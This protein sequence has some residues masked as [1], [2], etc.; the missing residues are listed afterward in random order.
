MRS[1]LALTGVV[2]V[3]LSA[4]PA[5]AGG[6]AIPMLPRPAM[7][8]FGEGSVLL[9]PGANILVAPGDR[10]ARRAAERL[11]DMLRRSRGLRLTIR[12]GAKGG[13][14]RFVRAAGLP[15][16][17]Y[18]LRITSN[19]AT[20]TATDNAGLFYGAVT[21][22]QLATAGPRPFLPL[23]V[24]ED[25]PR[26][27]WRGLMLDSARHYQTPAFIRRLIDAMAASKLNMLHWH[28]V[29][30]Q[31]W[32]LQIRKYPRL[33]A[34]GAWRHPATAPGAPPLPLEGGFY[35][36][37][38]V[39]AIVA[40]AAA[41][42][43]TIVPEIEM[44]GHALS[45]IRAYPQLGMG[46][47]VPPGVES[48]WGVFPWLYNVDEPTIRFLEDVLDEV[49][50]LFPSTNIHV[51]G[52]EAVKDQ[53]KADPRIQAKIREL[54]LKDENA[55]QGWLVKRIGDYLHAHGRRLIGWDEILEGGV[56]SSAAVMSWRGI[57]GAITAAQTGHDTI[58]SP[59][60]IL[61]FDNVQSDGGEGQPG[62]GTTETLADVYAFDPAP[63]TLTADQQ[64]HILG[65]QGNVWTEHIRGDARAAYMAFPRALAVAEL[66]WSPAGPRDFPGFAARAALQLERLKR[67]GI[68]GSP[69]AFVPTASERFD[70][71][72]N[73]VTVALADQTDAPI[74]YTL[75]GS[76]P[77]AGSPLY[78]GPLSFGLPTRLRATAFLGNRPLPGRF[79]RL[80]D[81]MSVRRR[82]N[83]ALATCTASIRLALEDDAP[84]KGPRAVFMT[85]IMHPCWI[86]K[87][88]PMDGVTGI[89]VDVG[90]LPFNFQ[91]GDARNHIV[92]APPRTPAGEMEVRVDGCTGEPIAVLPLGA[93]VANPSVT[94][95]HAPI[96][97]LSG[98]HDLCF[99]YTAR[100]PEPLWAID[101]VQLET[102][103]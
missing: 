93:A 85:D 42:H 68:V 84:A 24:V 72:T 2:L 38:E 37:A 31:G 22:W 30:D 102:K 46:V 59:A 103:K 39:R 90:Q 60:P 43:V 83:D 86:Y 14:I 52:D 97:P 33:T 98:P 7:E 58:L 57:S 82:P 64:H 26:F 92:F 12:A 99:T 65:L 51:G 79:D 3:L 48:D 47:P 17:G 27:A 70:P 13:A 20:I 6:S 55:L 81:A 78:A 34:I 66:G 25:R 89:A 56:D 63:A 74:R 101:A 49:M 40:Y 29:D 62:R 41:R 4:G 69:A 16:E 76:L 1:A 71:A 21:L 23:G 53:W 44:P 67:L 28:L 36:Q 73:R 11:V 18:R 50:A 95:L 8:S 75:D 19:G 91:I 32:R 77:G 94:R 96:R 35:S 61:Y 45:A 100:G 15:P 5:R 88:A 9:R 87:Q 10:G 54:G 80:Y